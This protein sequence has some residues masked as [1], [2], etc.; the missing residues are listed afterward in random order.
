M[1]NNFKKVLREEKSFMKKVSL[2]LKFKKF[3][4]CEEKFYHGDIYN[5][6]FYED[7]YGELSLVSIY[8]TAL[9]DLARIELRDSSLKEVREFIKFSKKLL[10]S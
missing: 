7:I 1:K 8:K 2:I 9:K 5:L 10:K 3:L 4:N 6:H